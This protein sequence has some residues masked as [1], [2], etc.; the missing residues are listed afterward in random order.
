MEERRHYLISK[1]FTVLSSVFLCKCTASIQLEFEWNETLEIWVNLLILIKPVIKI[2]IC[3]DLKYLLMN[4][5][6]IDDQKCIHVLEGVV[7][8]AR[9]DWH[10]KIH[11]NRT[12]CIINLRFGEEEGG[13]RIPRPTTKDTRRY[14]ITF[15]YLHYQYTLD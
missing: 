13:Q 11:P 5:E 7:A 8:G 14:G 10:I 1:F 4:K 9:K 2:K 6:E 15:Q 12:N 3:L